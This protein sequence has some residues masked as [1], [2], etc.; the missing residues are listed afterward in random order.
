MSTFSVDPNPDTKKRDAPQ[1]LAQTFMINRWTFH[2]YRKSHDEKTI[3]YHLP[4]GIKLQQGDKSVE[5]KMALQQHNP[6]EFLFSPDSSTLAFWA[7]IEPEKPWKRIAIMNAKQ[8]NE[9]PKIDILYTPDSKHKPFGMEWSPAGDALFVVEF[10]DINKL[11]YSTITRINVPGGKRKELFRTLGKIDFFMPP[12]SR[13][14]SSGKASKA[15]YQIIFGCENGLYVMDPKSGERERLSKLPAMG[16]HNLEWNPDEKKNQV[17]LFFKNPVRAPDGRKFEGVYLVDLDKLKAA[18]AKSAGLIQE[19]EFMEQLTRKRDIHTLWFSP[20]GT[21]VTWAGPDAIY[22]RKPEDPADKTAVIE[23]LDQDD[24]PLKL[25]GVNWN[26]EET[27]LVFAADNQVWVYDLD[28]EESALKKAEEEA[29][30]KAEEEA[31]KAEDEAKKAEDEAKK[32]G[33]KKGKD[34]ERKPLN[35]NK[36][37]PE[38]AKPEDTEPTEEELIKEVTGKMPLKYMVAEFEKGFTA[39]PQWKKEKGKD[40]IVLS[41]FENAKVEMKRL[42]ETPRLPRPAVETYGGSK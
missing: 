21:Y 5:V 40:S 29:K 9:N 18:K 42:R 8:L 20:K 33:K 22:F 11:T 31:K 27:K 26:R 14:E 37:Q 23:V 3:I 10:V 32:K 12:V 24:N 1:L 39:E 4:D 6:R 41:V 34:A 7:P 38:G 36:K 13:F 30:K 25:K 35:A 16:L 2:S 28:P 19:G 17:V 15:P